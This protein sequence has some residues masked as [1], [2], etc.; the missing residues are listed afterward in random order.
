VKYALIGIAALAIVSCNRSGE[1]SRNSSRPSGEDSA[2]ADMKMTRQQRAAN[3]ITAA[4]D[5][6]FDLFE[7]HGSTEITSNVPD[8]SVQRIDPVSIGF[9]V[10]P[11]KNPAFD[12]YSF[13]KNSWLNTCD[14]ACAFY[15]SYDDFAVTK[16]GSDGPMMSPGDENGSSRIRFSDRH[17]TMQVTK[18]VVNEFRGIT[19]IES[20]FEGVCKPYKA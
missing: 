9:R 12:L 1:G 14:V 20:V 4:I 11:H 16:N 6:G 15:G 3:P 7:C 17:L 13:E 2:G 18:D 5:A 10:N 19:R 8:S